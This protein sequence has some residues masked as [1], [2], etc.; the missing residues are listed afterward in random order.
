MFSIG[1][2]LSVNGVLDG[3]RNDTR[4]FSLMRTNKQPEYQLMHSQPLSADYLR[5]VRAP[6]RDFSSFAKRQD[7]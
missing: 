1:R 3:A 6:P 7:T 5:D 4:K 2:F